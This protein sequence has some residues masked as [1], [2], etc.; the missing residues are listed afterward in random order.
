MKLSVNGY[1]KTYIKT[2]N[3]DKSSTGSSFLTFD[4]NR[5]ATVYVAHDDRINPKPSWMND[6]VDTCDHLTFSDNSYTF[7]LYAQVFA[8]GSVTLGGNYG[9]VS[10]SMY[11]VVVAEQ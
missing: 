2:A 9:E 5:D 1:G 4:I 10:S 11:T 8:A 3:D 7:S 6:F